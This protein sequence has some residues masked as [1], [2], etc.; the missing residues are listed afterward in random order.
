MVEWPN[1]EG[2]IV[3]HLDGSGGGTIPRGSDGGIGMSARFWAQYMYTLCQQYGTRCSLLMIRGGA[4][5]VW[6]MVAG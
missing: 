6:G 3:E 5:V 1:S 4:G 2:S